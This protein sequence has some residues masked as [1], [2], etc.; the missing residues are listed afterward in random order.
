M[1]TYKLLA[2]CLGT[3]GYTTSAHEISCPLVLHP[4]HTE[5]ID[6]NSLQ[7]ISDMNRQC[8]ICQKTTREKNDMLQGLENKKLKNENNLFHTILV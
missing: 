4:Y 1:S 6:S 5:Y 7:N 3:A 8:A 2:A